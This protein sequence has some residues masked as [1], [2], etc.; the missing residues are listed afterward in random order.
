MMLVISQLVNKMTA[1]SLYLIVG[2]WL[3]VSIAF[4]STLKSAVMILNYPIPAKTELFHSQ[5]TA[6]FTPYQQINSKL[7][8]SQNRIIPG[9]FQHNP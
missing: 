3:A 1:L 9:N 4:F 6:K 5:G 8:Y 7:I 2:L